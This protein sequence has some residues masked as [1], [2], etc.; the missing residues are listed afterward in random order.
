MQI[1]Q[2]RGGFYSYAWLENL[3]GCRIRNA[4][5]IIPES[6][7]LKAGDPVRLHPDAPPLTAMV[8]DPCRAIVLGGG[9]AASPAFDGTWGFYVREV[10]GATR[11]LTRSRWAWNPGPLPWLGYRCLLEPA[12]FLMER[13]MLLTLKACA[14]RAEQSR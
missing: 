12:H 13:K 3:A 14:E 10:D 6:Q 5:R 4:D 1:G 7:T 8:V 9:A 11:L 2:D